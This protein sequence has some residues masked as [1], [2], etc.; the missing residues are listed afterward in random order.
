MTFVELLNEALDFA[1]EYINI[2][3]TDRNIII[4][5]KNSILINNNEKW[6]KKSGSTFD[7][8]MGSYDGS[9]RCELVGLFMLNKINRELRYLSR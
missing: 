6:K 1:S 4:Q 8:T 3:A 2:T 7:M 5:A 9:E